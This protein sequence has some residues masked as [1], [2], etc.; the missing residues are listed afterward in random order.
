MMGEARSLV[1][2][3][4][5]ADDAA[6]QARAI[7]QFSHTQGLSVGDAYRVQALSVER[8]LARGERRV[9]MKMGLTSK[10][11]MVQVGVDQ[12]IWGRL[13]DGMAV[14]DGS[15]VSLSG[16]VHPRV[17]PEIAYLIG[18]PLAGSVSAVQALDAVAGVAPAAEIIDSRFENFRFSLADVVADNS[19]CS[20]FVVGGWSDP[21]TPVDNLGIVLEADGRAAEIG[22]SAAILG[23]PARSL[24]AAARMAEQAGERLEPGWVV[25]AGAATAAMPLR[26]GVS[27]RVIVE[28]LGTVAF[29]VTP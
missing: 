6:R 11:K 14:A 27:V 23:D 4:A 21:S 19:S 29:S 17:E 22:S 24:V 15:E 1:E 25:L 5:C 13:T 16:Y 12:V 26:A 20:G 2:L 8:R 28:R 10:A 7:A 3:A 18:E 9:G